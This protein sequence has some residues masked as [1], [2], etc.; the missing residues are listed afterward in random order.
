M[1]SRIGKGI[2]AVWRW[3]G[4]PWRTFKAVVVGLVE[5]D[6]RRMRS[7]FSIA[8]LGGIIAL[9][10]QNGGLILMVRQLLGDALPGSLFGQMALNQQMWNN[11][12]IVIFCV[13]LALVVWGA[14]YVSA[15]YK[16]FGLTAGQ[17]EDAARVEGARRVEEAASDA[18]TEEREAV[19]QEVAADKPSKRAMPEPEIET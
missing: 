16:G 5:M 4:G 14:D 18:A 2:A 1:I 12:I 6:R 17:G 3:L 13:A 9:S 10:F 7:L 19:E 11:I 15:K 8:M